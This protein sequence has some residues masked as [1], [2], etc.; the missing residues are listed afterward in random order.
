MARCV[1]PLQ[2][3]SAQGYLT[4]F[5]RSSRYPW[6]TRTLVLTG[7]P[8]R[9]SQALSVLTPCGHD[10]QHLVFSWLRVL[11]LLSGERAQVQAVARHGP[12]PVAS[13][14]SRRLV[15]A[16]SWGTTTLRWGFA[17]H[18]MR[19]FPAPDAGR[20]SLVGDRTLHGP[21]GVQQPVAHT[22]RLRQ[23]HADVFGLRVV[24]LR[25]QWPVDRRPVDCA[26]IRRQG[27]P[28]DQP[29]NAVV[30][31]RLQDFPPPAWWPAVMGVADAA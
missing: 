23:H 6:E 17:D 19:A 20:R 5:A 12:K 7:F 9:V 27:T 15:C 26:L 13:P 31:P 11:H 14:H 1:S 25:A 21:R 18:A 28:D 2:A 3:E 29:A 8:R 4:D 30:R 24:G 10:R 16:A 22:T